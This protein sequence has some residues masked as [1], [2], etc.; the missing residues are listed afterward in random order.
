[1]GP[2]GSRSFSGEEVLYFGRSGDRFELRA[3][4]PEGEPHVL[5]SFPSLGFSAGPPAGRSDVS[6]HGGRVAWTELLGDSS[7]L[8]IAEGRDG[9]PGRVAVVQGHLA[10]PVWSPDGRWIAAY[11]T[12]PGVNQ[13]NA[14][15]PRGV[16]F[17]VGVTTGGQPSA[18]PRLIDGG[19]MWPVGIAW[20]PD[21][22]AVTVSGMGDQGNTTD[23]WLVSLRE[24]DAPVNLTLDDPSTMW[25]YSLSPDG[26][27]I[28][29]AAEI[30]RGS[31]IWRIDLP[32]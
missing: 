16:V 32:R 9:A 10:G 23:I 18:P 2:G 13:P 6:V 14:G 4:A 19:A 15:F 1:T 28:A 27:Y 29:Y 24:G 7:A 21:S 25:D 22:R 11:Y 31:S 3:C 30:Q 17:V 26:R 20:L 12:P 5:R 8:F